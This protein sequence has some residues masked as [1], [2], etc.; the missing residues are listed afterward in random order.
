MPIQI[1]HAWDRPYHLLTKNEKHVLKLSV[2]YSEMG[3]LPSSLPLNLSIALDTSTSMSGEKLKKAFETCNSVFSILR[4]EDTFSLASFASQVNPLINNAVN[5][6][7]NR[8]ELRNVLLNC[9]AHGATRIDLA[10]AWLRECFSNSSSCSKVAV[11][12]TDGHSTDSSGRITSDFSDLN[13]NSQEMADNNITLF[14]V[15]LGSPADYNTNLLVEIASRAYGSFILAQNPGSLEP[16]LKKKLLRMQKAVSSDAEIVLKPLSESINILSACQI[17]PEFRAI[18]IINSEYYKIKPGNIISGIN[19]DFLFTV[20]I[21]RASFGAKEEEIDVIEAIFTEKTDKSDTDTS[22]SSKIS[23]L[24]SLKFVHS[25]SKAS[26]LDREI[27]QERLNWELAICTNE[28]LKTSDGNKTGKLLENINTLAA[29]CGKTNLAE[30]AAW[31]L[32]DFR[33]TGLLPP[34]KRTGLLLHSM[35]NTRG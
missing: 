34:E 26:I 30:Q 10:L 15:G 16:Q 33:K 31:N 27:D 20:E 13:I 11:L 4:P 1:V 23:S 21:P 29:N 8:D 25:M 32:N 5:S 14:T 2:I 22:L 6:P 3:A 12:I 9:K 18:N 19:S 17:R 28:L 35:L 24:C 7:E